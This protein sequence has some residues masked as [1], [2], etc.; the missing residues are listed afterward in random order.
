[1][2]DRTAYR[3]GDIIEAV[4][5]IH[6]LLDG[7]TFEEMVGDRVTK[8]AFER[9]LEIL[10]EASRHIPEE[11]KTKAPGVPW[12]RV[13]DIGNHLRHAYHRVDAGIL[14]EIYEGGDLAS[15]REAAV[16]L[17]ATLNKGSEL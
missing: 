9:F 7:R 11:L 5:A 4:D 13:G 12:R 8:A 6:S 10:S 17:R 15:L 14:W 3:L 1:M 2:A 16:D